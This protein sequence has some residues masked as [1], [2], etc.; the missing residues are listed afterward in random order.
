MIYLFLA[1]LCSAAISFV[2]KYSEITSRNRYAVT[3]VNF[4]TAFVV[5]L[6]MTAGGGVEGA[7]PSI[8]GFLKE[9]VSVLGGGGG[10]SAGSSMIWAILTGL[11][12][13]ICYFLGLI[14]IQKSI[15]ENGVSITGAF[16]RLGILVPMSFSLILWSEFPTALQL[17]GIVLAL[18]AIVGT[19]LSVSELKSFRGLSSTLLFLFLAV[20]FGEFM[21]K[22]FQRYSLIEYKSHFLLTVFLTAFLISLFSFIKRKGKCGKHELLVGI[23]AGIPNL[24][25]TY[26]LILAF[27][28]VKTTVAF[29]VYSASSIVVTALGGRFI[30]G[31][32]LDLKK[33]LMI[34]VTVLAV[35][36]IQVGK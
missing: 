27:N 35:V 32:R 25:T 16:S 24:F 33:K 34:A 15:R 2:F 10:F 28:H 20:G 29:P 17:F 12:G 6:F 26:F 18:T 13:G 21:N 5:S 9:S 1:V 3:S 8:G 36:L 7:D 22:F 4:F 31:E 19:N 11:V 14:F 30:F 23:A